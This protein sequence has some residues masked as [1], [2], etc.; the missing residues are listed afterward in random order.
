M[1]VLVGGAY[2]SAVVF[3]LDSVAT[4]TANI[5][6]PIPGR[7]AAAAGVALYHINLIGVF[8]RATRDRPVI[9]AATALRAAVTAA[10][11]SIA[12]RGSYEKPDEKFRRGGRGNPTRTC[13]ML[14]RRVRGQ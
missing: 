3:E 5:R 13:P 9:T 7:T 4:G 6:E 11:R 10:L 8:E 2:L 12:G 1:D 14:L